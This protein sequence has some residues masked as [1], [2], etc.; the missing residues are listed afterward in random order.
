MFDFRCFVVLSAV[1]V[2]SVCCSVDVSGTPRS[3]I[4]FCM[5]DTVFRQFLSVRAI[6]RTPLPSA[7]RSITCSAILSSWFTIID[8]SLCIIPV[9][10]CKK[11]CCKCSMEHCSMCA[12]WAGTW[13]ISVH[14]SHALWYSVS[15]V[16]DCFTSVFWHAILRH[17]E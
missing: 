3:L 1:S 4:C 10:A 9:F 14:L 5:L 13:A 17:L 16:L 12:I 2:F 8:I 6:S 15:S 11:H 7:C